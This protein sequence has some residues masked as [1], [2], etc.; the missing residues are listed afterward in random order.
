M[1]HTGV[2]KKILKYAK[3]QKESGKVWNEMTGRCRE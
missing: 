2:I 3:R 1:D